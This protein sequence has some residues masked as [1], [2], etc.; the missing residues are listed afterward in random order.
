M[1][2][3]AKVFIADD[4]EL[5]VATLSRALKKAGYDV[6]GAGSARGL[7]DKISAW[8]PDVVLLD[9]GLPGG[10]GLDVLKEIAAR[11]I[12]T[13]VVMLTADNSAGTATRAM[14]AGAT[15]YLTKPFDLDEVRLVVGTVAEK[16]RLKREVEY[17]RK[18]EAQHGQREIVGD[19]PLM[20]EIH[21]KIAKLA[22]AG[23]D[24]VLITGESGT[25]KELV[26]KA[27]HRALHPDSSPSYAPFIGVNC[28]AL[29]GTLIENEL[30]GHEKGS[31][32]DAK[33]DKQ[34]LFELAEGGTLLLDEIG[35]M[36]MDMQGKLLRVLEERTFRRIG[37]REDIAV[38]AAVVAATNRNLQE[39]AED[40]RF[41]GDL[42]YR[43]SAFTLH[44][45][46]LRQRGDDV[47]TLARFFLARFAGKY[48][49]RSI[50]GFSPACE[51]A[52]LS[53]PWPG[54]V[55]ELRNVIERIV[56][57]E[58]AEV[59]GME[60]LPPEIRGAA[61]TDPYALERCFVLP[62]QGV[63]L[64]AIKKDLILQAL[65]KTRHNKMAAA[66]LLDVT[67]DSLR[68]QMKRFRI[69]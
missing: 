17:L 33:K 12:E 61:T 18:T 35:D 2:A 49:K 62:A 67:Y 3:K 40:E 44:I 38:D 66:A 11:G 4:D 37:G 5:I 23:V 60:C 27:L 69:S 51:Q 16:Q 50:Q 39:L 13:E 1:T 63:S 10:D 31:F 26:A 8:S 52:L 43:L 7:A 36:P 59:I 57:L 58:S 45:P 22:A 19:S 53:Y 29:P 41:R 47:V 32:T 20:Q 64:D 54:N 55:R 28:T 30:F 46:P 25:G 68:Y 14:K 34:G 15:D 56:V 21:E 24:I 65:E 6:R 9:I 42:F 48:G